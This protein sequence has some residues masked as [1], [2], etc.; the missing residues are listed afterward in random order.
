[1]QYQQKIYWNGKSLGDAVGADFLSPVAFSSQDL[2]SGVLI[3]LG[4]FLITAAIA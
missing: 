3:I 4:E 1:M 2:E